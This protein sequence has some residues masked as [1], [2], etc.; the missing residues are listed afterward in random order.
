M[1]NEAATIMV[2]K[3]LEVMAK[4]VKDSSYKALTRVEFCEQNAVTNMV[5]DVFN[6]PNVDIVSPTYLHEVS[7]TK[8]GIL[9]FVED[10]RLSNMFVMNSENWAADNNYRNT[11]ATFALGGG[12]YSAYYL[13]SP[14]YYP[15]SPN[16]AL[17]GRYDEENDQFEQRNTRVTDTKMVL[18]I[19]TNAQYAVTT[20]GRSGFV[21]LGMNNLLSVGQVQKSY[22][23]YQV[24]DETKGIAFEYEI[25]DAKG[26]GYVIAEDKYIYVSS[27]V[28]SKIT[29]KKGQ[30]LTASKG[31]QNA[32]GT[33]VSEGTVTF[34]DNNTSLVLE[35]MVTY[36]IR[37]NE[38]ETASTRWL[39][40]WL[41]QLQRIIKR[42]VT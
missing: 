32:D 18:D 36:R 10:S 8:T 2:N 25:K 37:T 7:N 31:R 3:Y 22:A 26:L 24:N 15:E 4:A 39:G 5:V 41:S 6:I 30:L 9:S 34:S 29:F 33:W 28:D 19:L 13:S 40:K 38:V 12:G 14:N 42:L 21:V 23:T 17:Y 11:L 1:S 27:T 20:T 35:A 16:G